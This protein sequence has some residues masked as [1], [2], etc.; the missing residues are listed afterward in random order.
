M[1]WQGHNG[2]FSCDTW[3]LAKSRT[4]ACPC[5]IEYMS[6]HSQCIWILDKEQFYDDFKNCHY[7][8]TIVYEHTCLCITNYSE[9][10]MNPNAFWLIFLPYFSKKMRELWEPREDLSQENPLEV[11]GKKVLPCEDFVHCCRKNRYSDYC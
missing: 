5:M 2:L 8:V 4:H 9:N 1:L 11:H 3:N 7:C 6:V 10:K